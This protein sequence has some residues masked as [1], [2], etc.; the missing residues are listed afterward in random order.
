MGKMGNDFNSIAYTLMFNKKRPYNSAYMTSFFKM[1]EA[2]HSWEQNTRSSLCNWIQ[3]VASIRTNGL[4]PSHMAY[5]YLTENKQSLIP[6]CT[7]FKRTNIYYL[8]IRQL[9]KH[10]AP[11]TGLIHKFSP[12]FILGALLHAWTCIFQTHHKI[13][14]FGSRVIRLY[15]KEKSNKQPTNMSALCVYIHTECP[16]MNTVI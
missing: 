3:W 4:F 12:W 2:S 9:Q 6:C 1:Q 11:A 10:K 13:L 16:K 15:N 8:Q 14:N 7:S 5:V